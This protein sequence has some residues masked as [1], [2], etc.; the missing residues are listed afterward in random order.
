MR[1]VKEENVCTECGARHAQGSEFCWR[2]QAPNDNLRDLL[3]EI[4]DDLNTIIINL[5]T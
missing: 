3:D 4:A 1:Y 2:I 5:G